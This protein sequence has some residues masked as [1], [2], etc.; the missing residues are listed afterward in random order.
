MDERA[1]SGLRDRNDKTEESKCKT[2]HV[3]FILTITKVIVIIMGS[4][5]YEG[6][7]S[8][9]TAD[10]IPSAVE[11]PFGLAVQ[12]SAKFLK[13]SQNDNDKK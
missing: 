3:N 9:V 4:S 2:A 6:N 1:C 7:Y 10:K 13:T 8:H 5:E 11:Y 12:C